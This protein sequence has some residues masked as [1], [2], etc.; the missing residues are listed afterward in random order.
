MTAAAG[1]AGATSPGGARRSPVPRA[2]GDLEIIDSERTHGSGA[3]LAAA[4]DAE[5]S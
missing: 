5:S 4:L 2:L 3:A 1:H